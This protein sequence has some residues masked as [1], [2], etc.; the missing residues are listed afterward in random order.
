[1]KLRPQLAS[2]VAYL[3]LGRRWRVLKLPL[4][5][6]E[7]KCVLIELAPSIL[8]ADFAHLADAAN[9][10]VRGGG[11]VIH[12]DVMDGHFVPNL[13]IGPP[14]VASLRKVVEVPLDCHL[15]VEE[16]GRV[17][18]GFRGGGGELDFGPP[19]GLPPPEPHAGA[20]SQPWLQGGSGAESG[21]SGANSGRGAGHR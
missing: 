9:A 21:D 12:C 3:K 15:M 7:E 4:D 20:D 18:S 17:Y 16:P 10:A 11:T 13:T 6:A 1:M 2:G 5:H 8:S 14:V 19:G